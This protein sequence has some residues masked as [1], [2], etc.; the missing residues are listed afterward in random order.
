MNMIDTPPVLTP[1]ALGVTGLEF[2]S[3]LAPKPVMVRAYSGKNPLFIDLDGNDTID[4]EFIQIDPV[5]DEVITRI[6]YLPKMIQ[7]KVDG[8]PASSFATQFLITQSKV[9]DTRLDENGRPTDGFQCGSFNP[10]G[11]DDVPGDIKADLIDALIR[12]RTWFAE[13]AKMKVWPEGLHQ[14]YL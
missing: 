4:S 10:G 8:E 3:R 9:D 7:V 11:T 13:Q 5:N 6:R 2:K 1:N 12:W 14:D